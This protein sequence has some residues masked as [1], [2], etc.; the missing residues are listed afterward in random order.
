MPKPVIREKKLGREKLDG[1]C[2]SDGEIFIDPRLTSKVFLET[3][4]H[5]LLHFYYPDSTEEE[6]DQ[7][8]KKM[9]SYLW[10]FGYRR[11]RK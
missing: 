8:A 11:M 7:I 3:V 4:L 9:T 6:V 10:R 5:E 2:Y 1:C